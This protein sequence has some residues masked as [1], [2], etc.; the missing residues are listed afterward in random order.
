MQQGPGN[1]QCGAASQSEISSKW[2][3]PDVCLTRVSRRMRM[4]MR[5]RL[6][7]RQQS[8]SKPGKRS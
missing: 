2:I 8:A 5:M 3:L 4:R 1:K 6:N 7:I